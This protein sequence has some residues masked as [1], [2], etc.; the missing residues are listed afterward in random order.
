M[1]LSQHG[2]SAALAL[3]PARVIN[4]SGANQLSLRTGISS[5]LI[6]T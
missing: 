3:D 6:P 5:L 1:G 4:S 2:I